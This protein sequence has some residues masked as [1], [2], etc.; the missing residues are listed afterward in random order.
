MRPAAASHALGRGRGPLRASS[1]TCN[2]PLTN[3]A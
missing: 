3:A 2:I 1:A